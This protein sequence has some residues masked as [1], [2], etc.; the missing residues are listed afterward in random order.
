MAWTD[1]GRV[2]GAPWLGLPLGGVL[3]LA[4][5]AHSLWNLDLGSADRLRPPF[6]AVATEFDG[7]TESTSEP[8]FPDRTEVLRRGQTLGGVL[9]ELGIGAEQAH[10]LALASSRYVDPRQLRSGTP[11]H[12]YLDDAGDLE[13]LELVLAGRGELALER[14]PAGWRSEWN[15][16]AREIRLRHVRGRLEGSLEASVARAGAPVELAYRMADVLQWDLD[17]SR[18]LRRGD[19]FRVLFE[20]LLIEGYEPRPERVLAVAYGQ[21]GG[22]Q[23]EGYYFGE[24]DGAGYFDA[25]GR[26]LQKMF[27]RSPLPYSRVTSG[28]SNR[29][30]HP[31]LGVFRP[32]HG[33]DYGAPMGTPVRVTASGSVVSAQWDGGGGRTVKVRHANGYLT[34]YLHLSRFADGVRAGAQ[35]RQGDVIG[36]V[37]ATGLATAPHLDYRV[38]VK[39][40]W[41]DPLSIKAVSVEPIPAARRATFFAYRDALRA[42][43]E[44]GRPPVPPG[45]VLAR[46]AGQS[47]PQVTAGAA[48][49][50]RR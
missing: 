28:F 12:A 15:A 39:G 37:G 16:F 50:R 19:E 49:G 9:A 18:D 2:W 33:V 26:P 32:H 25:Q 1:R 4:G 6:A 40:R 44:T 36:Y 21:Q 45:E 34:A 38:Q 29:R 22:R 5:A 41:I 3:A 35:V 7:L 17:F 31:V 8:R 27:L 13:R 24:G 47:A 42:S 11:W 20:E 23:L 14:G 30:F 10:E 46:S 43:L 48:A